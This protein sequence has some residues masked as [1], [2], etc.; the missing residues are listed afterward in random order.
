L[1]RHFAQVG[2]TFPNNYYGLINGSTQE[3]MAF[4]TETCRNL[5]D[6]DNTPSTVN[7]SVIRLDSKYGYKGKENEKM[8]H[9]RSTIWIK[10][11]TN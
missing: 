4:S 6:S 10:L 1:V 3:V 2:E 7:V 9:S 5:Y 8:Y 11:R